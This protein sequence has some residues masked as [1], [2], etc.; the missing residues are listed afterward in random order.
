[1]KIS[2]NNIP[3][4]GIQMDRALSAKDLG[5]HETD[6]QYLSPLAVHAKVDKADDAVVAQVRVVGKYRFSCARC[7]EP[8]EQE[9]TDTFDLALEIDETTE[10]IDL[11][12]DIRQEMVVALSYRILCSENC[13]GLCKDCGVNLNK[14]KCK[15]K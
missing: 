15:C 11:A 3:E 13:A 1:M 9:R 7:L 2:L 14:E 8:I 5:L 12:E 6:V 4:E 10:F